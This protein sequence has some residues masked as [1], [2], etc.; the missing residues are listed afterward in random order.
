MVEFEVQ[1]QMNPVVNKVSALESSIAAVKTE[2]EAQS[3]WQKQLWGNG[4]GT[5]GYLEKARDED[6]T[7]YTKLL[8]GFTE[9]KNQVD[10][11]KT[12]DEEVKKALA[13]SAKSREHKAKFWIEV[14]GVL[15]ALG[16]G[17]W[18]AHLL[19]AAKVIGH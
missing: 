13:E 5:P 8:S 9:L 3:K 12:V 7:R 15:A 19:D 17:G 1:K 2:T 4:S 10:N 14:L 18:I 11:E 6:D 16:A